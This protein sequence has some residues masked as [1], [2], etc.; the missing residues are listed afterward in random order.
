MTVAKMAKYALLPMLLLTYLLP[1]KTSAFL[2]VLPNH[3]TSGL[4]QYY[5]DLYRD[6]INISLFQPHDYL[7]SI[8]SFSLLF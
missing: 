4:L 5:S 1:F 3:L 6:C 2:I 8:K 7:I